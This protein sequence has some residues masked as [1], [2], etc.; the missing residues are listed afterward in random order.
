M[1]HWLGRIM[2]DSYWLKPNTHPNAK[3]NSFVSG[4]IPRG[5]KLKWKLGNPH[6]YSWRCVCCQAFRLINSE[7]NGILGCYD[8]S[9]TSPS[10]RAS[11]SAAVHLVA[12]SGTPCSPPSRRRGGGI[13]SPSVQATGGVKVIAQ[14]RD[15]RLQL[16]LIQSSSGSLPQAPSCPPSGGVLGLSHELINVKIIG[17]GFHI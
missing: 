12:P 17:L 15:P 6:G 9:A 5:K 2:S 13:L 11:S 1:S 8:F 14:Q 16:Q 3:R 10:T 4:K 7:R